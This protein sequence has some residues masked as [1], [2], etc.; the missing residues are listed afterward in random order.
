M[1]WKTANLL[2]WT[3]P[4]RKLLYASSAIIALLV[5]ALVGLW[6]TAAD[7]DRQI[8]FRKALLTSTPNQYLM[9]PALHCK[10]E[11][12]MTSPTFQVSQADLE[13]MW[14]EMMAKRADFVRLNIDAAPGRRHY[15]QRT[16]LMRFPDRVT[17]EFLAPDPA[18]S[19]LAIYSRSKYGYSDRGVNE[20]RVRRLVDELKGLIP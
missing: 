2:Y 7:L 9:C 15:Q 5:L 4:L 19:S 14:D 20:A 8:D 16:R 6:W 10:D 3:R 13:R 1:W 17:V 18:T 12:H 11:A